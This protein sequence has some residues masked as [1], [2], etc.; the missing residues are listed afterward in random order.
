M[1]PARRAAENVHRA[2]LLGRSSPASA[3]IVGDIAAII[4]AEYRE[5]VEAAR[6]M[7]EA[8]RR[9]YENPA[10]TVNKPGVIADAERKLKAAIG[11]EG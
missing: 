10:S 9:V 2:Y 6:C 7:L 1:T 11:G 4:E 8:N 5:V 3:P